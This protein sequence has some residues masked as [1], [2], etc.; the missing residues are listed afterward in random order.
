[1][2]VLS[3]RQETYWSLMTT[4]KG[5]LFVKGKPG[6]GKTAIFRHL[7]MHKGLNYIDL[8]LS[9]CDECDLGR[10]VEAEYK[11]QK[12]QDTVVPVWA[13]KANEEPTLICFDELNRAK[14][15][16]R[17]SALQILLERE[18]GT[19]FKFNDNVYIVALGNLG[20][21]DGTDVEEFDSALN[22]RAIHDTLELTVPEWVE[23]YAD[24]N[25]HP[26]IVQHVTNNPEEFY[27]NPEGDTPAY[28][29][30]RSW[31]HLSAY[32]IQQ[33]GMTAT[34]KEVLPV[35]EK[36]GHMFVGPMYSRLVRYLKEVQVVTAED[37]LNDFGKAKKHIE[38]L[39]RDI[40]NEIL[41]NIKEYKIN[42]MS[43]TQY[44]NLVKF[45]KIISEDEC[46]SYI[47]HVLDTHSSDA[48]KE[49]TNAQRLLKVDF[50]TY[51]EKIYDLTTGKKDDSK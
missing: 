22:N 18:I 13:L 37:V 39:N 23:N 12:C 29:S 33:V 21:E 1:M 14:K 41:A 11:G 27:K 28:A 42:D 8:R 51:K 36:V 4:L 10:P 15:E 5:F 6:I 25:V 30:P 35:V 40:K 7:A 26:L 2:S 48:F 32:I 31:D 38:G 50:K 9:M 44:K 47:L 3:T 20:E 45:L 46:V 43:A 24:E 17:D 16:V 34:A 49:G 19:D